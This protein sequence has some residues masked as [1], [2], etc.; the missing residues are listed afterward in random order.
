MIDFEQL[1]HFCETKASTQK[2]S[3]WWNSVFNNLKFSTALCY[4]K[5]QPVAALLMICILCAVYVG[6]ATQQQHEINLEWEVLQDYFISTNG[7]NWFNNSYW[8]L[9]FD[10]NTTRNYSSPCNMICEYDIDLY[11]LE[12]DCNSYHVIRLYS[13][14]NNLDGTLP[15]TI[16]N[17][18]R[19]K[20]FLIQYESS[21][22]GTV[23]QSIYHIT[24]MKE[25]VLFQT[26][27][28]GNL[29]SNNNFEYWK[30]SLVIYKILYNP[31]IYDHFYFNHSFWQLY[32]LQILKIENNDH[33]WI[34]LSNN[35]LCNF[36]NIK[37][38]SLTD[39]IHA[40]G[41][42]PDECICT[43]W[44]HL[45]ELALGFWAGV[46]YQSLTFNI[47][48]TINPCFA[49]I[50]PNLTALIIV[51]T[52]IGGEILSHSN[53]NWNKLPLI[54]IW[55]NNFSGSISSSCMYGIFKSAIDYQLGLISLSLDA[56]APFFNMIGN[57]F[58]GTL[59]KSIDVY[60]NSNTSDSSKLNWNECYINTMAL[61]NNS[62]D[63]TIPNYLSKCEY[64][65]FDLSNNEF[66]G[67]I[68]SDILFC[69]KYMNNFCVYNNSFTK[70]PQLSSNLSINSSY[71][72]LKYFGAN[73]ND[74]IETDI[75]NYLNVLFK[76][77]PNIN[78]LFLHNNDKISGDISKW[79][80]MGNSTN[81]KKI[82]LH[83]CNI[84]GTLSNQLFGY[85]I[86]LLTLFNN[87]ISGILNQYITNN[88]NIEGYA[89]LGN[90]FTMNDNANWIDSKFKSALHL[91][92]QDFQ[93]YYCYF[94]IMFAMLSYC[95]VILFKCIGYVKNGSCCKC[96]IDKLMSQHGSKS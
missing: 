93:I 28:T 37:T 53:C 94:C 75:G 18:K 9:L 38:I 90:Y 26:N 83:N 64:M 84:Y 33:L 12:C 55:S 2:Q 72:L 81:T 47:S 25:F 49:N 30:T 89:L 44:T 34:E 54:D 17:L 78:Y 63:G 13:Y 23:P 85:N 58:S 62:F 1:F 86:E 22:I 69:K 36:A 50:S 35:N 21:L 11:G 74:I 80:S 87:R 42:I 40:Y 39:S 73:N 7:N 5:M 41:T 68:P 16:G 29:S 77:F 15:N 24:T 4:T 95:I 76:L 14:Y 65:D 20:I 31:N 52:N 61:G 45:E 67:S 91:Y 79:K 10:T 19:L 32:N 88:T 27:L 6:V 8:D 43:K 59:P 82:T 96:I 70:L 66:S 92:L 48:G 57:S 51:Q 3:V 46:E 60:N 56:D 71:P